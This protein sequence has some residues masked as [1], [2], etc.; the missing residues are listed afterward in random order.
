MIFVEEGSLI[1][2]LLLF[3]F[4]TVFGF[5]GLLIGVTKYDKNATDYLVHW[6]K[7]MSR[8]MQSVHK[9]SKQTLQF[10][11]RSSSKQL[12]LS[13]TQ[14]EN[15]NDQLQLQDKEPPLQQVQLRDARSNSSVVRGTSL[16]PPSRSVSEAGLPGFGSLHSLR[17][18]TQA[19]V[20]TP[21]LKDLLSGVS[22]AR[23]N[24]TSS[25]EN[26]D[27][28]QSSN[29]PS[30]QD[31]SGGNSGNSAS[32]K[33]TK[34]GL[35]AIFTNSDAFRSF[36]NHCVLEFSVE[37]ILFLLEY[38]QLKWLLI[39]NDVLD[40]TNQGW[41]IT[42]H[43]DMESLGNDT[44]SEEFR[45][46][47]FLMQLTLDE[48]IYA[49]IQ[50]DHFNGN[51]DNNGNS[52]KSRKNSRLI[53]AL[54]NGAKGARGSSRVPSRTPSRPASRTGSRRASVNT[55]RKRFRI[56]TKT[57]SKGNVF[58]VSDGNNSGNN[59]DNN[60]NN[61]NN[62]NSNNNNANTTNYTTTTTSNDNDINMN[63]DE[64]I[65]NDPDALEEAKSDDN[66]D[67]N[68]NDVVT[69]LIAEAGSGGISNA[70]DISLNMPGVNRKES[71]ID[72]ELV[73]TT[74]LNEIQ[75]Q[76]FK[77]N[78]KYGIFNHF[79]SMLNDI[80]RENENNNNDGN[81]NTNSNNNNNNNNN[82]TSISE[83]RETLHIEFENIKWK[84]IIEK[85][86][87]YLFS[88]YVNESSRDCIIPINI[89]YRARK[90]VTNIFDEYSTLMM[91]LAFANT[92]DTAF[93]S[94]I[95]NRMNS[96]N[97]TRL[98]LKNT[99]SSPKSR[100][101]NIK[102][103]SFHKSNSGGSSGGSR[104][105]M[106]SDNEQKSGNNSNNNNTSPKNGNSSNSNNSNN[107]INNKNQEPKQPQSIFAVVRQST[108][109]RMKQLQQKADSLRGGKSALNSIKNNGN[110]LSAP[111]SNINAF[112]V[113][114]SDIT[115]DLST[116]L[117]N[118]YSK[119]GEL[120]TRM[121]K[122]FDQAA[123]DIFK[124]M[125]TDTFRRFSA[126]PEYKKFVDLSYK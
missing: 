44:N 106:S 97:K 74:K 47:E 121:I 124:L 100:S 77:I 22:T 68:E 5:I 62:N 76:L 120:G 95:M 109:E 75:D 39:K 53:R 26:K 65:I 37:N 14:T 61:N 99:L 13:T 86:L 1:R 46:F 104:G 78:K 24:P 4:V 125:S 35:R 43:K 66:K 117:D 28:G 36:A 10:T 98:K 54:I 80:I 71:L 12:E 57:N 73:D 59:S 92:L 101:K 84:Y 2:S 18:T 122:L 32:K 103:P 16:P 96:L 79:E 15:K 115:N 40:E 31:S 6:G 50:K 123:K 81:N 21:S 102:S 33:P 70:I 89:S 111:N 83:Q 94:A 56:R 63:N 82:D 29:E 23:S 112:G 107:S 51:N 55:D 41:I 118:E 27:G 17:I 11:F 7:K 85:K 126:T 25:T 49:F 30:V 64:I 38:L 110:T 34:I 20:N 119:F 58:N 93:D 8:S 19:S 45:I 116:E 42:L 90:A 67:G 52:L 72:E 87:H 69:D 108:M 9:L 91:E 48:C 114:I 88:H 113:N 105:G 3:I 60:S